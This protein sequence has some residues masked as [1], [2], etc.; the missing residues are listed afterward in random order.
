M[1]KRY[2]TTIVLLFSINFNSASQAVELDLN[3]YKG[4]VV[5]LDFWASW[6]LPCADSFPWMN[7]MHQQLADKGLV[8]IAVNLDEEKKQADDFLNIIPA[9]FNIVYDQKADLAELYKV[10]GMPSSYIFDRSGKLVKT[11]IGF[12][13]DDAA[14]LRQHIE[15]VLNQ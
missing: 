15:T 6:C 11:H 7:Q 3:Q 12:K 5:Y 14:S 13:N 1:L 2:L 4:K 9:S 8:V 10:K